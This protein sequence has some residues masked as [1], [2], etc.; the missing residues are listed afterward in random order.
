MILKEEIPV[1]TTANAGAGLDDPKLPIKQKK[2][3]FRRVKE[4]T[5][6]N[7]LRIPAEN[8]E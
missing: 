1:T 8:L 7:K 4:L 2:N 3:M 5:D 6:K